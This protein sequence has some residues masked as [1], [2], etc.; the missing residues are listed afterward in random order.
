M[1]AQQAWAGPV[2]LHHWVL[3]APQQHLA[4]RLLLGLTWQYDCCW[5]EE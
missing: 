4:V 1:Q 5:Q 2:T 3:H